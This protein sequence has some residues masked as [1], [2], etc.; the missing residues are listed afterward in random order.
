[1]TWNLYRSTRRNRRTTRITQGRSIVGIYK[2]EE[3]KITQLNSIARILRFRLMRSETELNK[4]EEEPQ[5]P[6]SEKVR[7]NNEL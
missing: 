5:V 3:E 7:R 1:M 2:R 6:S 4:D